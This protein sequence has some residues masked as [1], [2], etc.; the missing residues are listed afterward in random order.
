MK[1]T[2]NLDKIKKVIEKLGDF[3]KGTV[4]II[5]AVYVYILLNTE[6]GINKALMHI[7]ST[8]KIN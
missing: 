1:L 5:S 8:H 2:Q 3:D 6:N 7:L 4:Y